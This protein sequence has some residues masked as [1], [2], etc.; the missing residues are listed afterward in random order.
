[1]FYH[2]DGSDTKASNYRGHPFPS[3]LSASTT[4]SV[5]GAESNILISKCVTHV[6]AEREKLFNLI[7]VCPVTPVAAPKAPVAPSS[8]PSAPAV[9]PPAPQPVTVRPSG[10]SSITTVSTPPQPPSNIMTQRVLLSPDMQARL[11]CK[12]ISSHFIVS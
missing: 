3:S 12:L 9:R 11:P 4:R 8:I 10:L 7:P 1:M 2:H 6:M 5:Q